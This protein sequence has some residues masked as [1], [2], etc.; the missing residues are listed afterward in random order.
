MKRITI[1]ITLSLV[2]GLF[3]G[4]DNPPKEDN[5]LKGDGNTREKITI[6]ANLTFSPGTGFEKYGDFMIELADIEKNLDLIV[7]AA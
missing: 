6:V 3:Y 5:T 4:C 2:L 1:I 7:Q